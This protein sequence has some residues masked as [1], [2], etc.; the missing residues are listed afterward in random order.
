M[1]RDPLA[2][3][4]RLRAIEVASARRDLAERLAGE[5]VAQQR[6]AAAEAVITGELAQDTAGFA[7]SLAAWLPQ[8]RARRD[9]MAGDAR[10]AGQAVDNARRAL[11]AQRAQERAV[12]LV[13]ERRIADEREQ[14]TRRGQAALDELAQRPR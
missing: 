1:K 6:A 8:A 7:D 10:L 12:E 2:V 11:A 13:R 4:L 9:R 3:L 14:E 5:A